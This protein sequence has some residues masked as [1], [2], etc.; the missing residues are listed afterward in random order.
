MENGLRHE[1]EEDGAVGSASAQK[2]DPAKPASPT[3]QRK[4]SNVD[5]VIK[6][7]SINY[8]DILQLG[9]LGWRSW[10]HTKQER[11][12]GRAPIFD[13]FGSRPVTCD[14]GVPLGG[15]GGGSIGRSYKG[16]FQQFQL[17]P[18]IC[19]PS[20]V[21]AN[22]FSVSSLFSY[23]QNIDNFPSSEFWVPMFGQVFVSR[24][25][26]AKF[27]SVLSPKNPELSK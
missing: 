16:E 12:K 11:A 17:L 5:H 8:K 24:S 13:F 7:F 2:V 27:S 21:L 14:H 10:R 20:K 26:G 18:T 25:N 3:W 19:E 4:L 23:L 15:V 9:P 6:E 1:G 22:Q